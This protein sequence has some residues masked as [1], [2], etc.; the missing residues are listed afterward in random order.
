[1]ANNNEILNYLRFCHKISKSK[2]FQDE[3]KIFIIKHIEKYNNEIQKKI[4]Y[5]LDRLNGLSSFIFEIILF[6]FFIFSKYLYNKYATNPNTTNENNKLSL[7]QGYNVLYIQ[8][9]IK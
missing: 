4:C 1:M 9:K 8:S 2:G 3:R 5:I 6:F 7:K